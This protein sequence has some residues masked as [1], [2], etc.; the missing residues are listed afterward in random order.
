MST[1]ITNMT[2]FPKPHELRKRMP[3]RLIQTTL[4]FGSIVRMA[5]RGTEGEA[6]FKHTC[7]GHLES[8]LEDG[9]DKI[10]W[11]CS[12]CVDNGEISHW[13]GSGWDSIPEE[14]MPKIVLV[15][16]KPQARVS[17]KR[18]ARR[19]TLV[20]GKS[21]LLA[22]KKVAGDSSLQ[23]LLSE[24]RPLGQREFAIELTMQE[25]DDLYSLVGDLLDYG[26]SRQRKMCDQTL[27]AIAWAMDQV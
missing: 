2:H 4:Q 1:W 14:K 17:K 26:P 25:L 8:R 21:E 18:K 19:A 22:L 23:E 24:A 7:G 10:I 11:K 9:S 6:P 3:M 5:V 27:D 13:R 15:S 20:L 12:G 16:K